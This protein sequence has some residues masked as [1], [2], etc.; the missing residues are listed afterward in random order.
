MLSYLTQITL[1]L[2]CMLVFSCSQNE[3]QKAID[4]KNNS[5]TLVSDFSYIT[6]DTIDSTN[7]KTYLDKNGY[8]SATWNMLQD[9]K[10]E[11]TYFPKHN[12]N[13]NYA[14]FGVSP[15]FLRE[16]KITISGYMIPYIVDSTS[17]E[18]RYFLSYYP[19]SACFF[20][21]GNGPETILELM[22][23]PEHRNF[24][25]DEYLKFKGKLVLNNGNPFML[26]YLLYNAEVIE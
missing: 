12:A 15:L 22:L 18:L 10:I 6:T 24:R 23:N 13:G 7:H 17:K 3:E 19:N 25:S 1:F 14:E 5:D 2:S 4:L 11:E 21:G 26:N 20:C 8:Y 16:K 9:V